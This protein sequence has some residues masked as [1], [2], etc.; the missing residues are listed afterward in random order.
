L[1]LFT[2]KVSVKIE[3]V[4]REEKIYCIKL[5]KEQKC[6]FKNLPSKRSRKQFNRALH[7]IVQYKCSV[8]F[9]IPSSAYFIIFL[10]VY[11]VSFASAS[12]AIPSIALKGSFSTRVSH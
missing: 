2:I 10:A 12:I 7:F 3:K 9:H 8:F 6:I 1:D 5:N 11:L 4:M